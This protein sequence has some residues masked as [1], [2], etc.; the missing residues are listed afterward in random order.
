[1]SLLRCNEIAEDTWVIRFLV[2]PPSPDDRFP[3]FSA[4]CTVVLNPP[5]AT[6]H[7]LLGELSRAQLRALLSWLLEFGVLTVWSRRSDA[8]RLPCSMKVNDWWVT[9]LLLLAERARSAPGSTA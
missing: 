7:G 1:V 8:H 4:V 9:D 3:P 5:K 2:R 6:I